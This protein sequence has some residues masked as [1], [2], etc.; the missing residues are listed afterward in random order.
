M[1][2]KVVL[3]GII[4]L[5]AAFGLAAIGVVAIVREV[6]VTIRESLP[7]VA[8]TYMI[9]EGLPAEPAETAMQYYQG[10]EE[11][12]NSSRTWMVLFMLFAAGVTAAL[13]AFLVIGPEGV[14]GLLRQ[15]RLLMNREGRGAG[16][17]SSRPSQPR[18]GDEWMAEA[19]RQQQPVLPAIAPPSTP[20]LLPAPAARESED[21]AR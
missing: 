12:G 2:G 18:P 17:G 4:L 20:W 7:E 16:S 6:G 10:M 8:Q 13:V 15:K 1:K 5:T 19:W 14:S 9:V 11:E 21:D 3:F